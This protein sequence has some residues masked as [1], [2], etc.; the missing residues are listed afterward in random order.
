MVDVLLHGY[1]AF[2]A[3][4]HLNVDEGDNLGLKSV[5]WCLNNDDELLAHLWADLEGDLLLELFGDRVLDEPTVELY[6]RVFDKRAIFVLKWKLFAVVL[7]KNRVTIKLLLTRNTHVDD[8]L[9][10]AN[11][12]QKQC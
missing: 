12:S 6:L 11:V 3:I 1:Q 10:I 8:L 9:L 7:A 4:A 2:L 5:L